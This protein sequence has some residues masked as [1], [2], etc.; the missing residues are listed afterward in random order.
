[1]SALTDPDNF[2]PVVLIEVDGIETEITM[3]EFWSLQ[4]SANADQP[5]TGE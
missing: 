1:V 5:K 2:Q 4:D 3:A